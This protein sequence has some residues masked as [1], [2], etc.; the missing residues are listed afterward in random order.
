MYRQILTSIY[1][2]RTHKQTQN[3]LWHVHTYV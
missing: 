3:A 1:I 2:V